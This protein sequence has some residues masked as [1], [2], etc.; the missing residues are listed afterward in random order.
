MAVLLYI[1][2]IYVYTDTDDC[3]NCIGE[4]PIEIKMQFKILIQEPYLL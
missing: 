4:R 1:M 3:V 2:S